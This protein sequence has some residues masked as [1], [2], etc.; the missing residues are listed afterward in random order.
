[1]G[2]KRRL[3]PR[4]LVAGD[5]KEIVASPNTRKYRRKSLA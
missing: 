1:M 3:I 5:A 2:R 4:I